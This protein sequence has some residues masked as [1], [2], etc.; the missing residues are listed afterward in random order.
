MRVFLEKKTFEFFLNKTINGINFRILELNY[1]PRHGRND[2]NPDVP[3]G[4]L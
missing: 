4:P 3:P 1:S 2:N